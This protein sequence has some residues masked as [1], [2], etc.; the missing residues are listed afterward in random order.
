MTFTC[1]LHVN[2]CSKTIVCNDLICTLYVVV[3]YDLTGRQMYSLLTLIEF[4]VI[5]YSN[6]NVL[7]NAAFLLDI[8]ENVVC[9]LHG[10]FVINIMTCLYGVGL[11]VWC[12]VPLS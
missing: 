11:G 8:Q 3:M 12:L 9:V 6:I 4:G 10:L 1:I 2:L 7:K 5:Y